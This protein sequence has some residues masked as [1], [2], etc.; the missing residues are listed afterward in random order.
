MLT[1]DLSPHSIG[2]DGVVYGHTAAR[3]LACSTDGGETL[4]T[5]QDFGAPGYCESGE[6][7]IW[8]TRTSEGYVVVTSSD[9]SAAD[10]FGGIWFGESFSGP[11]T[12]VRTTRGIN[13]FAISK[14]EQGPN[15]KTLLVIG[16]YSTDAPQPPHELFLSTDGG[17][18]WASIKTAVVNDGSKN[19]H[20][21]GCAYDPTRERI[22]SSQGDNQNSMWAYSDDFGDNWTPVPIPSTDPLYHA[23][24]PY[25]QPTTVVSFPDRV[26]VTP[27]RAHT[28]AVWSMPAD[29]GATP[30]VRWRS[31]NSEVSSA[32]YGR[33][34]Y[35]QAG[36][37]AVIVIPDASSGTNKVYFVGTGDQGL[38]WHL[39]YTVDLAVAGAAG[40]GIVGPDN[41]GLIY[42]R[43][44]VG[45]PA[46]WENNLL[47]A[48]MPTFYSTS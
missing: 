38:S 26:C 30:R 6:Y 33:S 10:N 22:W 20:F 32:T 35:A 34:P 46:P 17:E 44:P 23:D 42:W 48:P 16:E 28:T 14:P 37:K 5:G 18:T 29:T 4:V 27:D 36:N 9:V 21:H 25:Q 47:V 43:S 15:G 31:P 45:T 7:V 40:V 11:F 1:S 41:D 3:T 39:L 24:S 8:V 2:V 13:E 19:S 12:K